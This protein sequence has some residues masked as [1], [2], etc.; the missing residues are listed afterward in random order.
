[1]FVQPLGSYPYAESSELLGFP[2][3]AAK[4]RHVTHPSP[5]S[6]WCLLKLSPKG[7]ALLFDDVGHLFDETFESC[8]YSMVQAGHLGSKMPGSFR[9]M[10]NASGR[11]PFVPWWL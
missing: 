7:N 8:A 1:M 6:S 9:I 3:T 4:P 5:R 11:L 10:L 2:S